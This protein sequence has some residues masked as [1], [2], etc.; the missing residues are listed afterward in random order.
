M[1]SSRNDSRMYASYASD[2]VCS[3]SRNIVDSAPEVHRGERLV[4]APQLV[5]HVVEEGKDLPVADQLVA[6]VGELGRELAHDARGL[7]HVARAR[8]AVEV[9]L[10]EA[11]PVAH[12]AR[13]LR[14]EEEELQHVD[15]LE[16]GPED[17]AVVLEAGQAAQ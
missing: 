11:R 14:I 13:G 5:E 6:L 15:R 7:A 8:D 2:R 1:R 12:R 3:I 17:L 4:G 9:L 10:H 16:A